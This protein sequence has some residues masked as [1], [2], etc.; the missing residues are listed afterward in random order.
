LDS[1]E[2]EDP[3]DVRLGLPR[4]YDNDDKEEMGWFEMADWGMMVFNAV[5]ICCGI[6]LCIAAM[7][8]MVVA[9]MVRLIGGR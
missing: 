7:F 4:S 1:N 8:V 9:G 6:V 3:D 5:A 2:A